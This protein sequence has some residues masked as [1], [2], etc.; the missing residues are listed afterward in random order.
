MLDFAV[1]S[2]LPTGELPYIVDGPYEKGRIHYLCYQYN[3][4]QFLKLA[5]AH[6]LRPDRRIQR[7]L[8]A[9]AGFLTKG[10]ASSG[11]SD[12]D[13][14]HGKP[15]LDY[16]TAVLAAALREATES[17]VLQAEELSKR[18]YTRLLQRQR[19]DGSFAYST[20]DYGFLQDGR[21]YP[22]PQVMTL[23]HLLYAV[24]GKRNK[25]KSSFGL[26]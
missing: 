8:P 2:Q 16:F 11:A 3:A 24:Y 22:R 26:W 18:C 15:E 4:F 10:I 5:W 6:A 23:F 7:V 13:C 21:S 1:D 14:T 20:G 12:A 19:P 9:L 17:G 25:D